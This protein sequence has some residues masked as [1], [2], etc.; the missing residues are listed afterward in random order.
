MSE[1]RD[2]RDGRAARYARALRQRSNGAPHAGETEAPAGRLVS[3]PRLA[4][5][6]ARAPAFPEHLRASTVE[7]LERFSQ[8]SADLPAM[9]Y[10]YRIAE[11]LVCPSFQTDCD[12]ICPCLFPLLREALVVGCSSTE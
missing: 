6:G 10:F 11:E 3:P 5:E 7:A 9:S 2:R 1:G 12:A 8:R 4:G